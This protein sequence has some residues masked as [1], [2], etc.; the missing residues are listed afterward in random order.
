MKR[1]SDDILIKGG[2]LIIKEMLSDGDPFHDR[3]LKQVIRVEQDLKKLE[4]KN[5][6]IYN[7]CMC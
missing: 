2:L 3:I 1:I 6:K 5:E 7:N 4:E